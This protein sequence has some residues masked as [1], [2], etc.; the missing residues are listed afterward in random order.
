MK[1]VADGAARQG[2]SLSI[3]G[4]IG[5][6]PRFLPFLLGIGIRQ[7]SLDVRRIPAA[8]RCAMELSIADCRRTAEEAVACRT[9]AEAAARLGIE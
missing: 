6:N 1:R 3:C 9:V 8:Q 7:F 5:G 2:C 4:E